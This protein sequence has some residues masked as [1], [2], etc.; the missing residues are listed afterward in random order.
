MKELPKVYEPQQV[1]SHFV[2]IIGIS[3]DHI[4]APFYIVCI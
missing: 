3:D 2:D 1:E 4:L